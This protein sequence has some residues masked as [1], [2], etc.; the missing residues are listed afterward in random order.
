M[1]ITEVKIKLMGARSDRLRAFC[2]ITIDDDFVIRDLRIIE[3]AKG[4]FVAMPSR[5]L[6]D[7][8]PQCGTKN[9]LRARFCNEC[10]FKLNEDRAV[11]GPRA[12]NKF[13]V[14]IAH[15][16]N[17][18]CRHE[19]QEKVLTAYQSELDRS[20]EPGYRPHA[21]Y[22]DDY[23]IESDRHNYREDG[24]SRAAD[25]PPPST[26]DEHDSG[27]ERKFGEGLS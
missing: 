17:S 22:E 9:H 24:H 10:G 1:N 3:G 20:K 16:I 14:D 5:K 12:R 8:C 21:G 27:D 26:D 13:H 18:R 23:D 6:T 19:I 25:P 11:T 4:T 2:S 15:P 7:K